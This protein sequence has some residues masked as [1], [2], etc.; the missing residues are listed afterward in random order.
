MLLLTDGGSDTPQLATDATPRAPA[1]PPP[2]QTA[3]VPTPVEAPPVE[4]QTVFSPTPTLPT[5][6]PQ[7]Q[8]QGIA[9]VEAVVERYE[10]A[11]PWV[12][13]AWARS[14]VQFFDRQLPEPCS[15]AVACVGGDQ[16]L[17]TLRAVQDEETVLHELAHV[18]NNIAA[19]ESWRAIR[20]GFADHYAGCYSSRATTP[21][22]LQEELLAD[23]MVI[24]SGATIKILSFG[25]YGYYEDGLWGSGFGGCLVDS[26]EPAPH[27]L[28]AIESELFNCG[29]DVEAAQAAA[30][31]HAE[32]ESGS[33]FS[34]FRSDEE[35][36]VDA[37]ADLVP[38]HCADAAPVQER[39]LTVLDGI[40]GR[41]EVAWPWVRAAW[42]ASEVRFVADITDVCP[43]GG[44][45]PLRPSS[46]SNML[47]SARTDP[48]PA[49]CAHGTQ[50]L[51][52]QRIIEAGVGSD[53]EAMRMPLLQALARIW[54]RTAADQWPAIRALVGEQFA[55]C[56]SVSSPTPE[57]LQ[58]EILADLLVDLTDSEL[59]EPGFHFDGRPPATALDEPFEG[60]ASEGT[61]EPADLR[62]AVAGVL[63]QCPYDDAAAR[64]AW[65]TGAGSTSSWGSVFGGTVSSWTYLAEDLCEPAQ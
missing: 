11:W 35:R 43:L 16:L 9:L 48:P 14:D 10:G 42:E 5:V 32:S 33:L 60:C 47:F 31:A 63:F 41:Y 44:V 37:W 12:R 23:A 36:R 19:G 30:K 59:Y 3:T 18:W 25:A 17:L 26:S 8:E 53:P 58:G 13:N 64:A 61:E 62:L 65:E 20:E 15:G 39:T 2:E 29:F 22:R 4:A 45:F 54:D 6:H 55:D 51:L 7:V 28:S 38:R 27:L 49:T 21:E 56:T 46:T 24:A 1:A 57:Q 50:L 40:V 34:L 52:D